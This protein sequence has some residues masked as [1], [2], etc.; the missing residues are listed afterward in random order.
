MHPHT[1]TTVA[2]LSC[3]IEVIAWRG[4]FSSKQSY[5]LSSNWMPL[6]AIVTV[7]VMLHQLQMHVQI[8]VKIFKAVTIEVQLTKRPIFANCHSMRTVTVYWSQ[9]KLHL[10]QKT[11]KRCIPKAPKLTLHSPATPRK[12]VQK[13]ALALAPYYATRHLRGHDQIHQKDVDWKGSRQWLL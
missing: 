5:I 9:Q 13:I 12:S 3:T 4:N 2:A 6:T 7:D 10:K 8:W 11:K 1:L